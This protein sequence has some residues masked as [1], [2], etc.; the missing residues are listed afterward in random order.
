LPGTTA[1]LERELSP[2]PHS[3]A[4]AGRARNPWPQA[5]VRALRVDQSA[6]THLLV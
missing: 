2:S 3:G 5:G 4:A 1:E 6:R